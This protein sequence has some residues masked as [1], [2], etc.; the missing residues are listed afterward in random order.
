MHH[1]SYTKSRCLTD[2]STRSGARR[3]HLQ[4]VPS[5]MLNFQHVKWFSTTTRPRV[6]EIQ[7]S[8][9]AVETALPEDGADE[10]RNASEC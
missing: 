2:T 9:L 8:M 3:R 5:Q 1:L 7:S 6:A 10:R 4:G